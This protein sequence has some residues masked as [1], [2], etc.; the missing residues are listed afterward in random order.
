MISLS[1]LVNV[2]SSFFVSNDATRSCPNVLSPNPA[3]S[4]AI[5]RRFAVVVFGHPKR[6]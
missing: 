5:R 4:F 2:G 3:C 6:Q 1:F